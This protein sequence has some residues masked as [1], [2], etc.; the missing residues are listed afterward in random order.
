MLGSPALSLLVFATGE[1][2]ATLLETGS[3]LLDLPAGLSLI[4]AEQKLRLHP[5]K[6]S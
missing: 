3:A 1:E 2:R 4:S 5:L 6:A